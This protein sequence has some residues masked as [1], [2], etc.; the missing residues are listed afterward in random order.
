MKTDPVLPAR[1][2]SLS[3]EQTERSGGARER[4]RPAVATCAH[5]PVSA[6]IM[7]SA[8]RLRAALG[9]R[10]GVVLFTGWDA[11]DQS[12]LLAAQISLALAKLDTQPTLLV[13]CNPDH[14]LVHKRMDIEVAPGFCDLIEGRV[15]IDHAVR[16]ADLPR[17]FVLPLGQTA[18]PWTS[19]F[20]SP[21]CARTL[22]QLRGRY[23]YVILDTGPLLKCPESALLA[24]YSDGAVGVLAAGLRRREHAARLTQELASLKTPLLGV[25]LFHR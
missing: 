9:S 8:T 3:P 25:M 7:Q 4:G 10:Q 18:S 6:D 5:V 21:E 24:Q 13:D 14:P 15:D 19:L 23:R 11:S 17:I 16:A 22:E 12:G 20:S 2:L 1:S